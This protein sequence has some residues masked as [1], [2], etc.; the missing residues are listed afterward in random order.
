VQ[1]E[2][3]AVSVGGAVVLEIMVAYLK[4]ALLR[5]R[6]PRPASRITLSFVIRR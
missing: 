4:R 1:I 2:Q 6:P 5:E 3:M